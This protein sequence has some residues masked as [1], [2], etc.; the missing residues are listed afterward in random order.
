[1][2]KT[3]IQS[4]TTTSL[5]LLKAIPAV[6]YLTW[7]CLWGFLLDENSRSLFR[8]QSCNSIS[9]N[10]ADSWEICLLYTH[11][12]HHRWYNNAHWQSSII[13]DNSWMFGLLLLGLLGRRLM[14]QILSNHCSPSLGDSIELGDPWC[15]Y[16]GLSAPQ[17][18]IVWSNSCCGTE[19]GGK[20]E[21][22]GWQGWTL[23]HN[24]SPAM[25]PSFAAC[26][27]RFCFRWGN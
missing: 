26:P 8:L 24:C 13:A 5:Y 2:D 18:N 17:F 22:G 19:G 27:P 10:L 25:S 21:Q 3:M 11:W 16:T 1:M 20:F 12:R 4:Q 9:L 23:W 15:M 14:L 7:R 6:I